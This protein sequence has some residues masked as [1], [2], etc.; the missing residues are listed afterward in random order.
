M[1]HVKIA[2]INVRGIRSKSKRNCIINWLKCNHY[3]IV[4]LQETY[5]TED[6]VKEVE[7]DFLSFG[8]IFSAC[9]D[10]SHSRGV[11]IVISSNLQGLDILNIQKGPNGRKV[12]INMKSLNQNKTYTFV[13]VYAPNDI[14]ARVTF[15]QNCKEWVLNFA[16]DDGNII[17]AGDF[18][19][20]YRKVDK[21]SG[22]LDKSRYEFQKLMDNLELLDMFAIQN[23]HNKVF[24]YIHPSN[25]ERNSR[26]DYILTS[27]HMQNLI[28]ETSIICCPAPDHKAVILKLNLNPNKRGKG[29]WK[30]NNSLLKDEIYK[31]LI[32]SEITTATIEYSDH[33]SKQNL[34]ELIKIKIK[35][36]TIKYATLK[37]LKRTNKI[38]EIEHEI[39]KID[40][41]MAFQDDHDLICKR[42]KL[43]SEVT[44]LYNS[45]TKAAYIRSRAKWI[46]QGEK[47][48]SYFLNLEKQNQTSNSITKLIDKNGE[49][50]Q[51]DKEILNQIQ[52]FYSKLYTTNNPNGNDID[53]YLLKT[54]SL[55][56]LTTPDLHLCEG[57]ISKHECE[58][59]L[60]KIK[61]NK[62]PG[63]DGL[64]IE[65]YKC[66]WPQIGDLVVDS[67]NE[68]F[69][70]NTLSENRNTSI[71]SLFS[72]KG[73]K[74]DLKTIDPS[75]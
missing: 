18:N 36:V 46:D 70:D 54:K 60:S 28:S 14:N 26:I 74:T 47:S 58:Q 52:Q 41:I 22:K 42:R 51:N 12:M 10:S 27:K 39:N 43:F 73:E 40:K 33:I 25:S 44:D 20:T 69:E 15:L 45:D 59:A 8:T 63:I 49:I 29:Y 5:I 31:N 57:H 6:I 19:T 32:K 7:Q 66:F 65:F 68:A 35:E 23:P 16:P 11:S 67:F 13:S 34:L 24:S 56:K 75:V 50:A 71:V 61:G 1:D 62:S 2:S 4:C 37:K 21:A 55:N 53:S 48:T 17:L 30:L 64:S 3:D 72:K 9:S 38:A